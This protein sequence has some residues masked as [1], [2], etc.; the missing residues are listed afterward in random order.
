MKKICTVLLVVAT[1]AL[2]RP[3]HAGL[4]VGADVYGAK[5]LGDGSDSISIGYG[6]NGRLG[7]TLPVPVVDLTPEILVGYT[8]FSPDT[9]SGSIGVT[10]AMAGGRVGVGAGFKPFAY[11]HIGYAHPA[12]E[13]AG[14]E[15]AAD[16]LCTQVGG[17]LDFTALPLLNLGIQVGYNYASEGDATLTTA[18]V[19]R[20]VKVKDGTT[21]VDFGVHASIE[22]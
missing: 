11:W 7:Y 19:T 4:A 1:L 6:F 5:A 8:R 16:V 12:A 10:R 13:S 18:G 17:G 21:W 20:T 15:L 14:V 9:G 22:F 2:A 3:A